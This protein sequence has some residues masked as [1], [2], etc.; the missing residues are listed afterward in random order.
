MKKN[1]I[2]IVGVSPLVQRRSD[3]FYIE[4][5]RAKGFIVE[6]CDL[7]PCF[8][9]FQRY[10][11]IIETCYTFTFY[12]LSSFEEYLSNQNVKCTYFVVELPKLKELQ[13]L[14]SIL[15]DYGCYC[16]R[17]NP[18]ASDM[19]EKRPSLWVRISKGCY[20]LSDF[21]KI[22]FT[23]IRNRIIGKFFDSFD[24]N[25]WN[26]Y[27]SSGN[28]PNIDVHLNQ[29]DWVKAR[30]KYSRINELPDH[31]AVFCDEYFP[32]HPDN[33]LI[34]IG[35]IEEI[36]K[37]YYNDM[38]RYFDFLEN[39]YNL[40][41]IIAGHPKSNYKGVEFSGR[42][43]MRFK[44]VELVKYAD[45]VILHG[46]MSISYAVLFDK[47]ILLVTTPELKKL[48]SCY[49]HEI[50][51]SQYFELPL[52]DVHAHME[53]TPQKVSPSVKYKYTHDYMTTEGIEDMDN[54][55]IL[56]ELFSK[57]VPVV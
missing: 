35:N 18:N 36:A 19:S 44:T 48:R 53:A 51:Y 34:D 55:D 25:I 22:P 29:D 8:Y 33:E 14:F 41:I 47:P 27:I 15:R 23:A 17:I 37:R 49:E 4:P 20:S 40:K 38:N 54:V 11:E 32:Y 30:K 43:I 21:F 9:K 28:N 57:D 5:L 52:S 50:Y 46:S 16:V 1:K 24:Y 13:P 6:H 3:V 12:S 7:S 31:Y 10:S 2:I 26:M 39:K 45:F 42:Q 56:E